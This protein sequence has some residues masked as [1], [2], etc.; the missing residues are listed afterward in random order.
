MTIVLLIFES[1]T[2]DS[3]NSEISKSLKLYGEI[4]LLGISLVNILIDNLNLSHR[5]KNIL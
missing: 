3:Q 1:L 4:T 2:D 5:L